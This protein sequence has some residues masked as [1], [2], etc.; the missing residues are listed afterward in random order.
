MKRTSIAIAG[1][2]VAAVAVGGT[3]ATAASLITS[4]QIKDGAVHSVDIA[5]GGVHSQDLS[6][7]IRAQIAKAGT[8]G[9]KGDKGDKGDAGAPGT[10]TGT[11]GKDG[12]PGA[13]GAPGANGKDGKD[14][15]D[16][17]PALGS[18][19]QTNAADLGL[20][21]A[22]GADGSQGSSGFGWDDAK[23]APVTQLAAGST[24]SFTATALQ[25]TEGTT[26][27]F[28]ISFDSSALQFVSAAGCSAVHDLSQGA[29]WVVCDADLAHTVKGIGVTFKALKATPYTTVDVAVSEDGETATQ[30]VPISIG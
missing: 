20:D 22:P 1:L 14:G 15:R 23:N 2:A 9:Q 27:E 3:S 18:S 17:G 13:P 8:P 5:N 28:V 24:A 29:G 16:G 7:A 26:G 12:A 4:K 19:A 30:V 10:G 6:A 25:P 11:N 21:A